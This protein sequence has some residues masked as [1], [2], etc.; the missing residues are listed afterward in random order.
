M[1]NPKPS[2]RI[3]DPCNQAA[4]R[5]N[6][7]A[8]R[9]ALEDIEQEGV[10][11]DTIRPFRVLVSAPGDPSTSVRFLEPDS[12]GTW[13]PVGPA[14]TVRDWTDS[15]SFTSN[16]L[17]G[18]VGFGR[19]LPGTD[20]VEAITLEGKSR[21]IVGTVDA[22][23]GSNNYRVNVT[24][25]H[26]WGAYPNRVDPGAQIPI[27]HDPT[28]FF[29]TTQAGDVVVAIFRDKLDGTEEWIMVVGRTAGG[30][31]PA[32]GTAKIVQIADTS[33]AGESWTWADGTD[34]EW[35]DGEPMDWADTMP[36]QPNCT[37]VS[38]N[39]Q[40]LYPGFLPS[41][42]LA[43][44]AC[45]DPWGTGPAVWVLD[46]RSCGSGFL[47]QNDRYVAVDTGMTFDPGGDE[48][49][50]YA[51]RSDG[52]S[53][54]S[55]S[56]EV[57]EI[58][59]G[60]PC[61]EVTSEQNCVW[62]ATLHEN[63]MAAQ[64][65][66][67]NP[68]GSN[69]VDVWAIAVNKC[70]MKVSYPRVG[71]RFIGF[72]ISD[73]WQSDGTPATERP[74]YVFRYAEGPSTAIV[75][76]DVSPGQQCD[77]VERDED[78]CRWDNG[79]IFRYDFE[80]GNFCPGPWDKG[81]DI[82]IICPATCDA[83]PSIKGGE[84][85]VGIWCGSINGKQVYAIPP[86]PVAPVSENVR[87]GLCRTNWHKGG[88]GECD[89]VYVREV[90][91][92]QGNGNVSFVPGSPGYSPTTPGIAGPSYRV[93]LPSMQMQDPNLEGNSDAGSDV[94]AFRVTSDN[95]LVCVSDYLDDSI[96]T[97]KMHHGSVGDISHGWSIMNNA[98][99]GD[100][101]NRFPKQVDV[102]N[103]ETP[104]DI[105]GR[106][107]IPEQDLAHHHWLDGTPN[108]TN[109][110][111]VSVERFGPTG[112]YALKNSYCDEVPDRAYDDYE[113]DQDN[114]VTNVPQLP[115]CTADGGTGDPEDMTGLFGPLN[116]QNPFYAI[117]FI[118]RVDNS[119]T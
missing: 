39:A 15:Q 70:D 76:L 33:V 77:P 117:H 105:G 63:F 40:C 61:T 98:G 17:E 51:V 86:P 69:L 3:L 91:D 119:A 49:P 36:M 74:L 64:P 60:D 75:G 106:K 62:G 78:T 88:A 81:E 56:P 116:I 46:A 32:T 53:Q 45:G 2:Q 83:V 96:D 12:G 7:L 22:V 65:D 28:G 25:N 8:I 18:H 97:V 37:V 13:V 87:W 21:F 79:S 67:C 58:T 92:C 29:S 112:E 14:Y 9:E 109:D 104:G 52:A 26:F 107:N 102:P 85:F 80:D 23:L 6:F 10:S 50:V 90:E 42:T 54:L 20:E 103:G 59:G 110:Q 113:R 4:L 95:Q 114:I 100:M 38:Q 101:T 43:G 34:A 48:R 84:R 71:D 111:L 19:L 44:T 82:H 47:L 35:A 5:N 27:V 72:R 94:I 16:F 41:L 1:V 30:G 66:G 68:S 118:R 11:G 108:E 73:A 115:R 89:H 93:E 99:S 57:I 31:G 55:K 24:A